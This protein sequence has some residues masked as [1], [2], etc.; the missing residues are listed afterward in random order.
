MPAYLSSR[1]AVAFLTAGLAFCLYFFTL[2]PGLTWANFGADGGDLLAAAAVNGVPHPTGYPLYI[3]LLQGWLGLLGLLLPASDIAWRGNL[4]SAVCAALSVAVTADAAFHLLARRFRPR[5][6]WAAFVALAWAASP[7][8]W[9]QALITEVYALHG[10]LVACLGWL[11]FTRTAASPHQALGIGLVLGLGAA[12]HLTLL[13]LLP[14]LLYWLLGTPGW[15]APRLWLLLALGALPGLLLYLRIPWAAAGE[16]PPPVNWG[17]VASGDDLWWL[18]GGA[19]YRR[20]LFAVPP[21]YLLGKFS[22]WSLTISRQFTPVGFGIALAGLY[23]LDQQQPRRRNFVLLWTLPVSAYALTYNT[24]DSMIYLMPVVWMLALLLPEG[25]LAVAAWLGERIPRLRAR[26]GRLAW[27]ALAL[28]LALTLL[29]VPAVS[30]RQ[31]D[32]AVRFVQGVAAVLEPGSLVFSSADAETFALWYGVW[33]SGEIAPDGQAGPVLVNVALYQFD[34]YRALLPRLY[35][36]LP[37]TGTPDVADILAANRGQRPIFFAQKIGPAHP[38]EL[39]A[40]GPIWR[41]R[42]P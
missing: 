3:L 9:G 39:E 8:L 27:T 4:L 19:A 11:L 10:L 16:P 7:L 22:R 25:L 26:Q 28:W 20:Y 34:W 29:R 12:H 24:L 2:A 36:Q 23:A 38:Q 14:A 15:R 21:E 6:L 32:E 1:P 17:A 40:V 33:A 13:L 37:G 35:P 41:V 5:H 18:V 31:D 42:R 30:L